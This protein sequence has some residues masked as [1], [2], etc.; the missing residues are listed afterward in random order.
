M[1]VL[2][3]GERS[4]AAG[5]DPSAPSVSSNLNEI[6]STLITRTQ[7]KQMKQKLS[8]SSVNTGTHEH[9]HEIKLNQAAQVVQI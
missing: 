4:P 1:I 9:A 5:F 2:V 8:F 6:S 7:L 3:K